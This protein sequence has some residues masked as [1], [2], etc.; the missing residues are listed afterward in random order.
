MLFIQW[1]FLQEY[2]KSAFRDIVSDELKKIKSTSVA[3]SLKTVHGAHEQ[4][5]MLWEYDG[6][7]NAYQGDCE[8]ILLEMQRIFYEDLDSEQNRK[9]N[10]L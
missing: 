10:A 7:H 3:D 5:D 9:G 1:L 8:E 6:L 2:I 4:A